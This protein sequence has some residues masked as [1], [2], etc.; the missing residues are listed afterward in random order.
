MFELLFLACKANNP[1]FHT[2]EYSGHL[3]AAVTAKLTMRPELKRTH[4]YLEV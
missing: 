1:Y 2:V 3:S 4:W